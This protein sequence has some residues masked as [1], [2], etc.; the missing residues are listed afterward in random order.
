GEG[1]CGIDFLGPQADERA[2]R[3]PL[4]AQVV[5]QV[6]HYLKDPAWSFTLPVD[7]QGTAFQQRVWARL[8]RVPSG[9]TRS[10]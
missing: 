7:M 4:S 3:D 2:P 6:Y 9:D 8:R 10:Y 5:A 1:L